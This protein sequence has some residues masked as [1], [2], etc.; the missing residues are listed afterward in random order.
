MTR[1]KSDNAAQT[2]EMVE[3]ARIALT[4]EDCTK[5]DVEHSGDQRRDRDVTTHAIMMLSAV[6]SVTE[7]VADAP[8]SRDTL[9]G[10]T[11]ATG[12]PTYVGP[13]GV[14]HHYSKS[15]KKVYEKKR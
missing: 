13:R 3:K 7:K 4:S 15:G 2:S 5:N 10:G 1:Q 6:C 9:S 8:H 14:V 11:T 12:I